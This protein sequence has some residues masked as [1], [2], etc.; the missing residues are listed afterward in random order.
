MGPVGGRGRWTGRLGRAFA[1]ANKQDWFTG[2]NDAWCRAL[3]QAP[4]P[5][6]FCG[7]HLMTDEDDA[8]AFARA[9]YQPGISRP[10]V[11]GRVEYD[12]VAL[13]SPDLSDP[14]STL[15]VER[16]RVVGP[17]V[18]L[19]EAEPFAAAIRDRYGVRMID[20]ELRELHRALGIA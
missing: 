11:V 16:A 20:Q 8:W 4:A 10:C 13:A 5:G 2:W 15:R 17:I 14:P 18:V 1:Y 12:G 7:L 19:P 3:H 9:R 6:C